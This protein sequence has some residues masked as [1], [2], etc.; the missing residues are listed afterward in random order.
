MY[1]VNPGACAP[2]RGHAWGRDPGTQG[3][4]TCLMPLE[5]RCDLWAQPGRIATLIWVH[6]DEVFC[7]WQPW[8]AL[9]EA[10]HIGGG[11][12]AQWGT[13]GVG[14][15]MVELAAGES[16]VSLIYSEDLSDGPRSWTLVGCSVV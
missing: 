16:M 7:A 6:L 14:I 13:W 3:W 10:V 15:L 8:G 12:R 1:V 5:G 9:V 4:T 11:G 2:R